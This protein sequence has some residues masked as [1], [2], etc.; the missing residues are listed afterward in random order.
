MRL[1]LPA[2]AGSLPKRFSAFLPAE[3]NRVIRVPAQQK[4][5]DEIHRRGLGMV[6]C[7]ETEPDQ[8]GR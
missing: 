4:D 7:R 8:L 5:P 3:E 6:A 1:P 2:Q